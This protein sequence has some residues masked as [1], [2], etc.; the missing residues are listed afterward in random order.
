MILQISNSANSPFPEDFDLAQ[1]IGLGPGLTLAR[2]L[3]P[4]QGAELSLL[5]GVGEVIT[6]LILESP[7]VRL[8]PKQ[9]AQDYSPQNR[10]M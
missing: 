6:R 8:E 5:E 1:G 3:L 10:L 9:A 7:V 2:D 4:H